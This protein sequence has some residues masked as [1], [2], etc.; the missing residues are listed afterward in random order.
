MEQLTSAEAHIYLNNH[1]E[2]S[3]DNDYNKS[4]SGSSG[5]SDLDEEYYKNK[6]PPERT[7]EL[8][9]NSVRVQPIKLSLHVESRDSSSDEEFAINTHLLKKNSIRVNGSMLNNGNKEE[10]KK[11]IEKEIAKKV[12]KNKKCVK[13]DVGVLQ[14]YEETKLTKKSKR[15]KRGRGKNKQVSTNNDETKDVKT[16]NKVKKKNKNKIEDV[17]MKKGQENNHDENKEI[18]E[19]HETIISS[20]NTVIS[21][22]KE[23]PKCDNEM[24]EDNTFTS[25]IKGEDK[26]K[27]KNSKE[28]EEKYLVDATADE[29]VT[30]SLNVNS[31]ENE[32]DL[33]D[34]EK[35][36]NEKDFNSFLS[37]EPKSTDKKH[38]LIEGPKYFIN[39]QNDNSFTLSVKVEDEVKMEDIKDENEDL[40]DATENAD[41]VQKSSSKAS[42][43]SKRKRSRSKFKNVDRK[44]TLKYSDNEKVL[45]DNEKIE[46]EKDFNSFFGEESKS[47]DLIEQPK[48]FINTQ[49]DNSLTSSVKIEDEVEM[50]KVEIENEKDFNSFLSEEPES[51]GK[52]HDLIEEPKD[53]IKTQN[54]NSFMSSVNVE[55]EV[56]MEDVKNESEDLIDATGN[57]DNGQKSSS[58]ASKMSKRKRS[59]SK[60]KNVTRKLT[61][62]SSENEKVLND[63]EEIENEKDFNSFLS[64][65]PKFN[66]KNHD[67]IENPKDFIKT[68]NDNSFTSSVKVE[69][70]ENVTRN[71]IVEISENER[72]LNDNQEIENQEEDFNPYVNNVG[73]LPFHPSWINFFKNNLVNI[74][75]AEDFNTCRSPLKSKEEVE[76]ENFEHEGEEYLVDATEKD[77]NV[78]KSSSKTAKM[79][80]RKKSRSKFKNVTRTLTV[81]SLVNEKVLNDNEEI[82]NAK[83]FNSFLSEQPKDFIKT[84]ND[85]SFTSSVKVEDEV[86]MED[87][88]DESE[89]LIDATGNAD[90]GQKSSSKASK[91]SKRERSRSK[92]KNVTRKLT[93]KSSENEK[94]LNDNEEIENK[95]DFKSFLIEEQKSNDKKYDLIEEPKDFIN[96]QNDNS[97]TSSVKVEDEVE[98]EDV[99]DESEALIDATENADNGQKSSSKA[100]KMSKRKRG[101]SKFKNVTR[102]LT[103]KSSENEI[104]LNDNEE[105]KNQEEDVNSYLNDIGNLP[106][107]PSWHDFFK[108]NLINI[109]NAEDFNTCR[110]PLKSKEEVEVENFEHEGEEYLVDATEKDG[111]VQKSSSK[112][113]K[114]SKR[115]KSRSKFKNVTR[116]LTVKSLVNEKVLND[117]EEIENAKVFNSFLSE[118]PKDFI[119][120][121]NDNSFTS[122]VKVED[123]VEMEDVKDESE[124]LI[125][126]TGN[127]D[128]GQKSSSKA[129]KMSKR[130][131]SRSKFKNVTR[132]LTV[133]SSENEKVLNDNEEIENKRDFK[134]FLIEE[135]KSNDKKYDL[136][137]EPKD[138]IN[139]QNDNS[140]TSS[141]KVEDEVEMEDVKDESEA[142]ID[143]T[144]NADNGQKSSSKASKMSKRKRGRSK[145]KNVTRKL[146]VKSSE[147]EILLNDNEEIKNQEEDVN[148]YLNDI[149]NLPYH[150]SWHDFFKNNLINIVNAE[151]FNTCRSPLKSKEEVEVENF[152]HEGEE[153]LVDA[154]EKDGNVQKSSSKTAKMSKRKKSRSKFKNVT[155]TLT[156]KSLVNEKVLN[157]NEEIENEKDFNSFLSEELKSNDKK[158]DLIEEPKDFINTNVE[159]V[160]RNLI[161]EIL[162]NERLLNDNQEIEN[163]EEDFD[164][165][166]NNVGNLPFHPS[167]NNFFKNNLDECENKLLRYII[168]DSFGEIEIFCI[169][170]V[171]CLISL[172]MSDHA[173]DLQ[174]ELVLCQLVEEYLKNH[175]ADNCCNYD[176]YSLSDDGRSELDE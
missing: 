129:S 3:G 128:N 33:N 83:V 145:F 9:A 104:L 72:L 106:Y 89:D 100:S 8:I 84:Q 21:C 155:R 94:V 12:K 109:V 91:M 125:D 28:E 34:N 16:N 118:Q 158:H 135:Q 70:K 112:T 139:T 101:R 14:S 17:K 113:A 38:D 11:E 107:H 15:G 144:E 167:W 55:D 36:E 63:N 62:K 1:Y 168:E 60:F 29:D 76:V 23:E 64:K 143:A 132:K 156:V 164:S 166:L 74:V 37:E 65:E 127:A 154:T 97:F 25:S 24:H 20:V 81:K 5:E 124:D 148:S 146:T 19:K 122:S 103:V 92:F 87:V 93:V 88:K 80:K 169:N 130:E 131:R 71:L 123:E 98:M 78:Q 7:E 82:E 147:N 153:Y 39:T 152:E 27:M 149:G 140:F 90:N 85:N 40:V 68:Q 151:D 163:Q 86:E 52:K 58:K 46:N 69:N 119:K 105:I 159:N 162:E 157:D 45:N 2:L 175:Y 6:P 18:L 96:T 77:G 30:D 134:S 121:Q 48:D 59:R 138:F 42:K 53:F 4:S 108:N 75:N 160:T 142:L 22:L 141:V 161:V 120:T 176:E 173:D 172:N 174:T 26:V 126:A 95:R 116:T 44:L 79:S 13:N 165:Y 170:A 35:I 137:E 99:K 73:N 31:P 49:K 117:N 171:N 66:D 67:L 41:N 56:E 111:N 136:I 115:K 110:S 114:M 10:I 51:N 50:E 150:P 61:V 32:K 133:K 43:M 102:K 47:N 57:D 54:D